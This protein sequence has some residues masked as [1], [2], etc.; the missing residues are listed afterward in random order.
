LAVDDGV[1][2]GAIVLWFGG[3]VMVL[4]GLVIPRLSLSNRYPKALASDPTALARFHR[5]A[6]RQS[7]AVGLILLATG[8][9]AVFML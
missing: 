8:C 1:V 6:G 5:T 4:A 9:V 3:A 7:I 2:I